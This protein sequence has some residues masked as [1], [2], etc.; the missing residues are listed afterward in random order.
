MDIDVFEP[1]RDAVQEIL[2]DMAALLTCSGI[3]Y[4]AYSRKGAKA[5]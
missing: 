1:E 3:N 5:I 4:F 2:C